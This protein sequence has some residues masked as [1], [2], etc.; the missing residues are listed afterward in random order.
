M[1]FIK[2]IFISFRSGLIIAQVKALPASSHH[3][4]GLL[5]ASLYLPACLCRQEFSNCYVCHINLL[6]VNSGKQ[7]KLEYTKVEKN[8]EKTEYSGGKNG[9]QITIHQNIKYI[10]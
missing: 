2:H 10:L 1:T 9:A 3:N 4:T 7:R 8:I 6:L 5:N